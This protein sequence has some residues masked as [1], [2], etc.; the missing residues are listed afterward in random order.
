MTEPDR[1]ALT[2]AR[3]A[4]QSAR[5]AFISA[6]YVDQQQPSST[7]DSALATARANMSQAQTALNTAIGTW[8][9][10]TN[11][12]NDGDIS[13]LDASIP[14]VFLP[15]RVETR[16]NGS[17]LQVRIF[18]DEIFLNR[19]EKALTSDEVTAGEAYYTAGSG[20]QADQW[21]QMVRL[22]GAPRSAYI[23]RA[24]TPDSGGNF[25]S[26]L[27]RSATWTRPA[28]AVLPDRWVVMTK[29]GNT[30]AYYAG[31]PIP[32]PLS[33]TPDPSA[34]SADQAPL[35]NNYGIDGKLLWTVDFPTAVT[36][37]MAL[38]IPLSASDQTLGFDRIVVFGVKSSL[39][40]ADSV[41]SLERLI[42]AHHYT[43]GVAFVRQESVTNNTKDRPTAYPPADEAGQQSFVI[44]RQN[45]PVPGD[46]VD[47]SL[48]G[49]DLFQPDGFFWSQIMGV[50]TGVLQNVDRAGQI[51]HPLASFMNRA[52]WPLT[53]RS[54]L[55]FSMASL[56]SDTAIANAESY[57][58]N[59]V[60]ARGPAPAFRVGQ[61]PYGILPAT[62]LKRWKTD[63]TD[64]STDVTVETAILDP[65]LRALGIWQ[66]ASS[67][68]KRVLPQ[69]TTPDLD[70]IGTLALYP[71]MRELRMR[72]GFG[73]IFIYHLFNFLGWDVSLPFAALDQATIDL[74]QRLGHPEWR[75]RIGRTIFLPFAFLE[76]TP[77]V[78]LDKNLSETATLNPNYL[79][80]LLGVDSALVGDQV[81]GKPSPEPLLYQ[82]LRISMLTQYALAADQILLTNQAGYVAWPNFEVFG[83]TGLPTGSV[84]GQLGNKFPFTGPNTLAAAGKG[85]SFQFT[86][87]IGVLA[88]LATTAELDRL[89]RESLDLASHRIDPWATAFAYRRLVN[90]RQ[91]TTTGSPHLSHLGGY[92]WV[93]DVRPVA[94]TTATAPDGN[95]A[96]VDPTNGGFIHCPGST[97]AM[98][99]A[100]L[101]SGYLSFSGEDPQKYAVDLSSRRVRNATQVLD[102]MRNGQPAGAVLGYRFERALQEANATVPGLNVVRFTFRNLFPLVAGQNGVD[103]S[104]PADHVAARNVVDGL[105]LYRAY[106]AGSIAFGS[107]GLPPVG[108]AQYT[109]V[110]AELNALVALVDAVADLLVGEGVFQLARGNL[111]GAPA[112]LDNMGAGGIPP[113]PEIAR[114]PRSG[115][116][117]THRVIYV[118]P[119]TPLT[120]PPAGWP[121]TSTPRGDADPVLNAWVGTLLG[122]PTKVTARV[123]Y[124]GA[125]AP[126][127]VTLADLKIQP[128]DVLALARAVLQPDQGSLLD[129]R[130]IFALLGDDATK[131]N[132]SVDYTAQPGRNPAVDRTFP[133]IME[134]AGTLGATLGASRP[135]GPT[136]LFSP[137]GAVNVTQDPINATEIL[138]RATK[139]GTAL[140]SA[141][142]ALTLATPASFV[143][144]SATTAQIQA[145]Q[146]AIRGGAAIAPERAFT[147][148]GETP[149]GLFDA[150]SALLTELTRRQTNV[151]QAQPSDADGQVQFA[152]DTFKAIF[153]SDSFVMP[154]VDVPASTLTSA[155][156]ARSTLLGGTDDSLPGRFLQQAMHGRAQLAAYRKL[157]LYTRALGGTPPRLDV[158]QLPVVPGEQWLALPFPTSMPPQESRVSLLLLTQGSQPAPSGT[159][160]GIVLDSWTE[161]IPS[162]TQPTSIAFNHNSPR[163]EAPQCILVAVPPNVASGQ[164]WSTADIVASLEETLDLAKV[165]AVDRDLLDIGQLVPAIVIPNDLDQAITTSSGPVGQTASVPSIFSQGFL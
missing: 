135:L 163:A 29:R 86:T 17:T 62:S 136:D 55:K 49:T 107:G 123:T 100:A 122:D 115:V 69:S 56:F 131:T 20:G 165:R 11:T 154:Q 140:A 90:L 99:A 164:K 40:G 96:E 3:S 116:G 31:N 112:S 23:L 70:L 141:I 80:T 26:V 158:V 68:V 50:H 83:L 149:G 93:E 113:I 38:N 60:F 120:S 48:G 2:N 132:A 160:T 91:N 24:L 102:E 13:R 57:F 87:A 52:M 108:T 133:E 125:P 5:D 67:N 127:P 65:L 101:R 88:A 92:A 150:A 157:S 61:V 114:S 152:L 156:A 19:H 137:A 138:G 161:I 28:E 94:R 36:V 46:A 64:T 159:W 146:S 63:T 143:A 118:F 37:G 145:L 144:A 129:A 155:F 142:N 71:T 7:N 32:E 148:L 104:Q 82:L 103:T 30:R 78:D 66:K 77:L 109:T 75:P 6:L 79:T 106:R 95:P 15:I 21:R 110:I 45:P 89:L 98:A 74:F 153:G 33:M 124:A 84:I 16:F 12:T 58:F 1:T 4:L 51:E 128:L 72:F 117:L 162:M 34:S 27:N 43:R 14:I 18:P 97:H 54:F 47:V 147:T 42:D 41:V 9:S 121:T 8:L 10:G 44:E 134:L 76:T 81:P 25:P 111:P 59:N 35:P 126:Q 85:A 22:F 119:S 53:Y 130:I 151:P 139:A 105:A 39:G 73:G